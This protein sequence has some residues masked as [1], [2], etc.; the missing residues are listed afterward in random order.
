MENANTDK[1]TSGIKTR[2]SIYTLSKPI[3]NS[4]EKATNEEVIEF[5][6][7]N[8]LIRKDF[9]IYE[10]K[11]DLIVFKY[12]R[13]DLDRDLKSREINLS[14]YAFLMA[15]LALI[16]SIAS[17]QVET[18]Y[19]LGISIFATFIVVGFVI[20]VLF[21]TLRINSMKK[22]RGKLVALQYG[23]DVLESKKDELKSEK[24][25]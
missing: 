14:Y 10:V 1:K 5:I 11:N 6:N 4:L 19:L 12:C 24:K 8:Y 2:N 7:T 21:S 15:V 20:I 22:G 17:T 16:M 23:I 13:N 9:N 18:K 25:D 3:S